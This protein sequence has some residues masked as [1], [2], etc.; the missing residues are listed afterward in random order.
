M[1]ILPR[2]ITPYILFSLLTAQ[3]AVPSDDEEKVL[4]AQLV[5]LQTSYNEVLL[6]MTQKYMQDI[7]KHYHM[8]KKLETLNEKLEYENEAQRRQITAFAATDE[9]LSEL[10]HGATTQ[11]TNA[12]YDQDRDQT[13]ATLTIDCCKTINGL[14]KK[15]LKQQDTTHLS[16]PEGDS[17]SDV[18]TNLPQQLK[19]AQNRHDRL[20][21]FL[22]KNICNLQLCIHLYN[23][24]L[25]FYQKLSATHKAQ[26]DIIT[27]LYAEEARNSTCT[28]DD[29]SS[30]SDC[31]IIAAP[32][33]SHK[34]DP[35]VA[36]T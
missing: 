29:T 30:D 11:N 5:S 4:Q 20:L 6:P 36:P 2:I 14:R 7:D 24:Q 10:T 28:V 18:Q 19:L 22:F 9:I 13:I 27:R 33:K 21:E 12:A 34:P 16:I 25:S 35:H 1:S 23:G 26:S 32:S 31:E 15:Y 8:C 17:Q 3:C